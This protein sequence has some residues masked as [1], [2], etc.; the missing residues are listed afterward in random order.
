MERQLSFIFRLE[1]FG[2]HEHI[3]RQ[4]VFLV[5]S[6]VIIFISKNYNKLFSFPKDLLNLRPSLTT[7]FGQPSPT[8]IVGMDKGVLCQVF[9]Q[10]LL[11]LHM[12]QIFQKNICRSKRPNDVL[13]KLL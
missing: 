11:H 5:W 4:L 7:H 2:Q 6:G 13:L 10:K 12:P 3:D 8:V 1:N 9:G